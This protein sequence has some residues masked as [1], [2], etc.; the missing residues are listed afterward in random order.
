VHAEQVDPVADQ[1]VQHDVPEMLRLRG[2]VGWNLVVAPG[3]IA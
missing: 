2:H 1:F 3:E